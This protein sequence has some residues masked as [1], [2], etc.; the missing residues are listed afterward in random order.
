MPASAHTSWLAGTF[1]LPLLAVAADAVDLS[2]DSLV[3]A[4][5]SRQLEFRIESRAAFRFDP[6]QQ[7]LSAAGVFTAQNV[8]GPGQL[9]R[10]SHKFEDLRAAAD[11]S[12]AVRSYECVEGTLGAVVGLSFCGNYRFGSNGIDDG[13]LADD[14]V[15]G[16]PRS[17]AGFQVKAMRWDGQGLELTLGA[18]NHDGEGVVGQNEL[19]L[20]FSASTDTTPG[21]D[22]RPVLPPD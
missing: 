10:L 7:V 9:S 2:L 4:D 18:G 8:V 17:L 14:E 22:A 11:G 20:R 5:G 3:Q 15:L 13:G 19:T 16:Q 21:G 6:D 1:L 12:L